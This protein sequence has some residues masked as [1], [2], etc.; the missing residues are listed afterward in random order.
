MDQTEDYQNILK[1]KALAKRVDGGKV[2][3][4]ISGAEPYWDKISELADPRL[5]MFWIQGSAGVV[6][7]RGKIH[8]KAN[9]EKS[10]KGR[11]ISDFGNQSASQISNPDNIFCWERFDGFLI[12]NLK[13]DQLL[14]C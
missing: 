7:Y 5:L 2:A 13:G 9:F 8:R 3:V 10:Y 12:V 1:L 11:G 6:L 4:F 14:S